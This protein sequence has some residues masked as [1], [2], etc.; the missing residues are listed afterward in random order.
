M[1]PTPLLVK[2]LSPTNGTLTLL[3][4]VIAIIA[5]LLLQNSNTFA[6]GPGDNDPGAVRAV[7]PVGDEISTEQAAELLA[8]AH[9]FQKQLDDAVRNHPGDTENWY[10]DVAVF[11]RAVKLAIEQKTF[12]NQRDVRIAAEHLQLAQMRLES[13]LNGVRGIELLKAHVKPKDGHWMLVGGFKSKIDETVQPFGL[14]V[15]VDLDKDRAK[16]ITNPQR[17]DVWLHGRG[18]RE[19][20]LQF[21]SVRQNNKGYYAPQNALT[22]H[23]YGRYSNAFKF[24]GEVDVFEAIDHVKS[25]TQ[26]DRHRVS[27]RGFSMGGAGCW[28]LAVHYPGFW[29]A[30]TPGAGFSET[31]EFLRVFQGEQWSP[32]GPMESLLNWYD[33][34]PWVTNLKNLPTIAY[35][36]E[37]DRQ[38]QAADMMVA[39]ADQA[40]M[41]IPHIIGPQTEHKIHPESAQI[42]SNQMDQWSE[43]G[44]PQL[45]RWIDFTTFTTRYSDCDWIRIE[46]IKQHWKPARVV[47]EIADDGSINIT[48]A[49]VTHLSL[50][51]DAQQTAS[52]SLSGS[53]KIDGQAVTICQPIS[54]QPYILHLTHR[55]GRWLELSQPDRGLRKRPGLQGPIDEALMDSFVMVRPSRP[56]VHGA[57]ERWVASEMDHFRTEWGRQFRGQVREIRDQD[58]DPETIKNCNL[59]IFGDPQANLV[60]AKIASQL[61]LKWTRESLQIRGQNYPVDSSAATMIYPNPL[62][63][64]R[65]IVLNSGFTYRQYAYLNNARQVPHLPDWAVLDVS[66]GSSAR[67]PGIIQAAGFFD[68]TWK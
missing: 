39:A 22:L 7:P 24:A 65:Y 21:L 66:Q 27:I 63:P 68:E 48:T 42:I 8:E 32:A 60:L 17:L 43:I 57:V 29:M 5:P 25:L 37:L 64:E 19:M 67:Q 53:M 16:E 61:P 58:L 26:I 51:F 49:D 54:G 36:G 40:G 45:R 41:K 9:R 10:P 50:L 6:D 38:K 23:P 46:G 13:A 31:R 4:T 33:C 44:R 30:A 12:Y 18:E 11:P 56:C 52:D 14:I 47:A 59:I 35:S 55:D 62:N 3:L 28:Q 2:Q 1:H 20:E 15:P 34:P